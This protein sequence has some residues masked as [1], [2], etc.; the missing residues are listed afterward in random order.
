MNEADGQTSLRAARQLAAAAQS[1]ILQRRRRAQ[2]PRPAGPVIAELDATDPCLAE[3]GHAAD[4]DEIELDEVVDVV[5]ED[6]QRDA[7]RRREAMTHT[8]LDVTRLLRLQIRIAA[9]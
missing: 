9:E 2:A 7:M 5:L 6:L 1:R 8:E 3:I 4:T